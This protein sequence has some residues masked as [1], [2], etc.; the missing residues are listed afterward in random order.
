[1]AT[2]ATNAEIAAEF[3]SLVVSTTT[4][5]TT[6]NVDSWRDEA[7]AEINAKVGV[8]YTTPIA[9]A[10]SP[11]AFKILRRIEIDL[12][13]P[14]V[15]A[16]MAVS[17]GAPALSQD[18]RPGPDTDTARS[19]R[20]RLDE[21][22]DGGFPLPDATAVSSENGVS[23]FAAESCEENFYEKGKDQW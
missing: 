22:R 9:S 17:T 20:K 6:A 11:E 23:S 10:T 4:L 2:Y 7:F 13:A 5:V 16:K 14:R 19:A 1:M 12:V 18:T 15:R 8:R 21:I 3:K